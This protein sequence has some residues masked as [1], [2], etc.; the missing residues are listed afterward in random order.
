MQ[1]RG[2][3]EFIH[4]FASDRHY[5]RDVAYRKQNDMPTFNRQMEPLTLTPQQRDGYLN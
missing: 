1:S 4:H 3:R 5:E 2:A